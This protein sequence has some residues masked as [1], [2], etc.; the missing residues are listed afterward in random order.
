MNSTES[1]ILNRK[2]LV[3]LLPEG[4][5]AIFNNNDIFPGNADGTLP[6][7]TN[8]DVF[9]L[10]GIKQEETTLILF[11][12][13]PDESMREVLFIMEA[14]ENFSKWH[15]KRLSI[16]EASELSGIEVV[17]T[18]DKLDAVL[19]GSINYAQKIGLNT[20]EH[21]RSENVSE[22]R[23]H[24][25]NK[26]LIQRYPLHPIVR[27][28]PLTGKLRSSK[29]EFEIEQMQMAC[30][31]SEKGFRR[32][33]QYVKPGVK[34]KQVMAEMIHEY[35]QHDCTWADYEPIVASGT[36]TCILHYISNENTCKDGDLLL[37]DAA[38]SYN[39]YNADLTRVIPVNGR[40][41]SRQKELYN[42]VLHIHKALIQSIRSG[43]YI[44]DIQ[45]L[46]N[47]LTMEALINLGLCTVQDLK[48][49]GVQH[50]R[51]Q[52]AYHNFGH[53]LGL[54]VHDVGNIFEP[55][56][57]NAIIT[58][59]PG[60]YIQEEG[61]GV[62]IENN[63]LLRKDLCIDLMSNIPIEAEEIEDLMN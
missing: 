23:D 14:D 50:F 17:F 49:K 56:P 60:I 63:V 41:S 46:C 9:W 42:S 21:P 18:M 26:A 22:T 47:E 51:D 12:N 54:A 53:Y 2:R 1:A 62:R 15:G 61:I 55:I 31:V 44:S 52:Y 10:S 28:A 11:P 43:M 39:C 6:F 25:F 40:Y 33:L 3:E 35:L 58:I 29:N 38:A 48:N 5:I 13:H 7:R 4:T 8:S 27:L 34:G 32:L 36:N 19:Q 45:N 59:E 57:E 16:D 30:N 20:I 37:L 24:R